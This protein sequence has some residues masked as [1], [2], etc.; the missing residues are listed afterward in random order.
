MISTQEMKE[1]EDN[2]GVSKLQLMENAGRGICK[3]IKEKFP[4]L[5]D[6]RILIAAYHGNNGGDGFVAA[7]H[8]CEE[9]ETDILFIGDESK[10]KEEARINFARIENNNRMQLFTQPED[11]SFDDYD[12]IID[13]LLGTGA[14]G[15]IKEPIAS[16]VKEINNSSAFKVAVDIPSGFNP[17]TGDA[18]KSINPDLIVSFHDIKK[19][20]ENLK[21]KTIII[22]IGIK[23]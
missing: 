7:R 12:I 16:V 10:F 6:K 9:T 4:N 13:A 19:G 17:N 1:L 2:C 3:T 20:M 23:R 8:L 15:E 22:D 14:I 11:I 21:D 5:K 18:E